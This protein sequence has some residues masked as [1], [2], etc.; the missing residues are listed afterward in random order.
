MGSLRFRVSTAL[1]AGV[2]GFALLSGVVEAAPCTG[3]RPV[4][5]ASIDTFLGQPKGL[6]DRHPVGQGGLVGEVRDLAVTDTRTLPPLQQL[7]TQSNAEQKRAIGAGLG[8]ASRICQSSGTG[9]TQD[10]QRVVAALNSPEVTAAFQAL[11]GETRTTATAGGAGPG[12]AGSGAGGGAGVGVG[13]GGGGGGSRIVPGGG[14]VLNLVGSNPFS[15]SGGS[16]S[17]NT[18]T[19]RVAAAAG[20]TTTNSEGTTVNSP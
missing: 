13:I 17:S 10:I 5:E 18:T 2:S 16:S 14:S 1:A 19:A 6:L 20:S 15:S 8:Q 11:V 3:A 12:G 7:V 9:T 4:T